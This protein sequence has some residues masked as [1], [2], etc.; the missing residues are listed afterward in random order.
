VTGDT[1]ETLD[2]AEAL[3]TFAH[4][5]RPQ[6]LATALLVTSNRADAEDAVSTAIINAP[7]CP[8]HEPRR[9]LGYLRHATRNAVIDQYRRARLPDSLARLAATERTI[10]VD[11]A[12][13]VCDQ[14]EDRWLCDRA[15]RVLPESTLDAFRMVADGRRQADVAAEYGTSPKAVAHWVERG[16]KR[17]VQEA[18]RDR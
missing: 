3:W 5:V 11:P 4:S 17:L 13:I 16:R 10:A 18:K 12:V 7:R 8:Y 14:A 6:L 1:N 9:I 2:G 15:A